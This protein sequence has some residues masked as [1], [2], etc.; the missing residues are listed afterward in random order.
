MDGFKSCLRNPGRF[1]GGEDS[2]ATVRRIGFSREIHPSFPSEVIGDSVLL[3][4]WVERQGIDVAGGTGGD[5]FALNT[6][7]AFAL[8]AIERD[9]GGTKQ[10]F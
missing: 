10:V 3:D 2:I 4:S 5:D 1:W 7:A 9:I 8:G 6:I